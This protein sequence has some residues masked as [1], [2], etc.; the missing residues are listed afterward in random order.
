MNDHPENQ[1]SREKFPHLWRLAEELDKV[2]RRLAQLQRKFDLSNYGGVTRSHHRRL[3]EAFH[4]FLAE[5][6]AQQVAF[7]HYSMMCINAT[8]QDYFLSDD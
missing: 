2:T 1:Q 5:A 3:H 8:D 4:R 6:S 7:L